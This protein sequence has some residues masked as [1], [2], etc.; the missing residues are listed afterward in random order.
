MDTIMNRRRFLLGSGA[1]VAGAALLRSPAAQAAQA[2]I[3]GTTQ[4]YDVRN[5]GAKGDG[6]TD[7]T[8]AIIRAVQ[9]AEAAGGGVVFFGAGVFLVN[10]FVNGGKGFSWA[11]PIKGDNITV[12]GSGPSSI[13]RSTA[14]PASNL[15]VF[16]P[17]GAGRTF[18]NISN[19]DNSWVVAYPVTKMQPAA[20]GASFIDVAGGHPFKTGD[21][22][23][24]RT[25]QTIP[26]GN[27]LQPDAEINAVTGVT[28]NRLYLQWPLAKP[29]VQEFYDPMKPYRTTA[30][31]LGVP[32][33]FGVSRMTDNVLRNLV[34][35]DL[36]FDTPKALY[37]MAP[38]Q[39]IGVRVSRVGGNFGNSAVGA[40]YVRQMVVEDI[41]ATKVGS[42]V[43]NSAVAGGATGT[44]DLIVRR[45]TC[46]GHVPAMIHLHEGVA[47]ARVSNVSLTSDGMNVYTDGGI[48]IRAR[49]YDTIVENC[50]VHGA[51]SNTP[52]T[53]DLDCV[54]GGVLRNN[55]LEPTNSPFSAD[56]RGTG[57][58]VYD[59]TMSAPMFVR[60]NNSLWNNI[61]K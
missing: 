18:G 55:R 21:T 36:W 23:F 26:S 17:H 41:T 2:A 29:Y 50:T 10:T 13:I 24:V 16:W 53:V 59:N 61:V 58:Q 54:Y 43:A 49:S 4:T 32:A 47:Q 19:Y 11:I 7:D 42:D 33:P 20:K 22:I 60:G 38:M 39:A 48:S 34:F 8:A 57:W 14:T 27:L 44:T 51:T 45:V 37:W 1:L 25:G 40:Q 9:A 5:Y 6:V 52:M 31:T 46:N 12:R 56:I 3:A 30:F 15:M 28:G 35:E